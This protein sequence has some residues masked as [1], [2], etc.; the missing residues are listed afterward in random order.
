[1]TVRTHLNFYACVIAPV[2]AVCC[3]LS[4]NLCFHVARK[5]QITNAGMRKMR[6][7]TKRR[8]GRRRRRRDRTTE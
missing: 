7:Q 8:K 4:F 6:A 5:D 2:L 1:M 3:D